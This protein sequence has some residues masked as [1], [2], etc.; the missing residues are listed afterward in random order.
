MKLNEN[1]IKGMLEYLM[2]QEG[3]HD[4]LLYICN[5]A[6]D[7]EFKS[8]DENWTFRGAV[9]QAKETIPE[10]TRIAFWYKWCHQ[11]PNLGGCPVEKKSIAKRQ[12]LIDDVNVRMEY[13][14]QKR[15]GYKY[16]RN[17]DRIP[18][19]AGS[20]VEW[21]RK[22]AEKDCVPQF[23][24][25]YS[26][27][28]EKFCK[29]IV[30]ELTKSNAPKCLLWL[31]SK[32]K[33]FFCNYPVKEMLFFAC[34]NM[35]E[36]MGTAV[37]KYLSRRF[38]YKVA[39]CID[40]FGNNPLWY[41]LHNKYVSWWDPSCKMVEALVKAGCRP[42]ALNHLALSFQKM[43]DNLT[44]NQRINLKLNRKSCYYGGN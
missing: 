2:S 24:I 1:A 21:V 29:D 27:H 43:V 5:N 34:A 14:F 18:R 36:K 20:N 40:E 26:L 3:G 41:L 19:K 15:A 38:P 44:N 11:Q 8:N 31:M 12:A 39:T 23:G 28:G 16:L 4:L 42:D 10:A 13:C 9:L 35:T 22:S 30:W 33:D 37:V 17:I 32:C 6:T 7:S 25:D